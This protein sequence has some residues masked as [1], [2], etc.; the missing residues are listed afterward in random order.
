MPD[1][2]RWFSQVRNADTALV[3][4]KNASLGE[5]YSQLAAQAVRVPNGFAVSAQAYRDALAR[6]HAEPKLRA[7]LDDFDKTDVKRLAKL[8]RAARQ[9]VYDATDMPELREQICRAYGELVRQYG[10]ELAVAVRSS[11]TAEDLPTASFAG[12]HE[13]YLHIQGER[14]LFEACRRC[15]ASIFTDRAIIYRIDNGLIISRSRCPWAS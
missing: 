2:I 1:Y 12:Q 13:S 11:A 6:A 4:G 14:D 10:S 3:G 7:L 5:M 9:I 15:F 8:A